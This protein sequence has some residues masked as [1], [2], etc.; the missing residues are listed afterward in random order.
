MW[1][2]CSPKPIDTFTLGKL[3]GQAV[4]P[5]TVLALYGDLGAGKTLLAQG[6]ADGLEVPG[7]V[8][9]PTFTIINEY[10]DG[11]LPFYH[12]D[13]YRLSGE[14]EAGEI[15]VDEYFADDAV[16]VVE[17]PENLGSLLPRRR[18]EIRLEKHYD[19][20]GEEWRQITVQPFI[21]DGVWLEEV[22]GNYACTLH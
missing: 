17:W 3:I 14:E 10:L 8:T 19:D 4:P 2:F 15:G 9:S 22:L 11:R 20:A 12:L 1:S 21:D 6:M 18:I 13:A 16:A 5:G 7:Y